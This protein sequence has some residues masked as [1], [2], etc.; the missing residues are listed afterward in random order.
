K[1]YTGHTGQAGH[2][3]QCLKSSVKSVPI[4]LYSTAQDKT[5]CPGPPG[6]PGPRGSLFSK[7]LK[8]CLLFSLRF[9]MIVQL[10]KRRCKLWPNVHA[11]ARVLRSA[12]RYPTPTVGAIVPGA[13]T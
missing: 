1:K 4:I 11:V 2:S 5:F 7:F 12:S 13:P 9:A 8:K 10:C 6:T 3:W